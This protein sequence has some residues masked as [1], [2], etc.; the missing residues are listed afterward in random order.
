MR[1]LAF[2]SLNE[3]AEQSSTSLVMTPFH[4]QLTVKDTEQPREQECRGQKAVTGGRVADSEAAGR[5]GGV[6]GPSSRLAGLSHQEGQVVK[7]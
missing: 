2:V 1:S 5:Q 7:K 3:R 4:D 6:M